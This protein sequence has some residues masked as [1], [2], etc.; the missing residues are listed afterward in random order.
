VNS[1]KLDVIYSAMERI[2]TSTPILQTEI[3]H[4]CPV[5]WRSGTASAASSDVNLDFP[6][7]VRRLETTVT[8]RRTRAEPVEARCLRSRTMVGVIYVRFAGYA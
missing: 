3:A 8:S 6:S 7:R 5:I 1:L 2:T 4:P